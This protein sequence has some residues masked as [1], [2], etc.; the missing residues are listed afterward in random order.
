MVWFR[1]GKS[2]CTQA[3]GFGPLNRF[4]GIMATAAARFRQAITALTAAAGRRSWPDLLILLVASVALTATAPVNGDFWWQ[5]AP[6][7]AL[8][9]AF[10]MDF[11]KAMPWTD[12]TAWAMDYYVKYPA[13]TILFYPPVF[14]FAEAAAYSLFG[15]HHATAQLV[16]GAF[17]LLLATG[18]Y[19]L[20]R[21]ILPRGAAIGVA[22]LLIGAPEAAYWGRQVML[23]IPAYGLL[24][25]SAVFLLCYLGNQGARFIYLAV[26]AFV[27]AIY[28]KYNVAFAVPAMVAALI[29]ARGMGFWRDRNVQFAAAAA[30]ILLMPAAWL[31]S[32]F[33]SINVESVV[34]RSGDLP[35]TD[36]RAWLFYPNLVP[37]Q[38]GVPTTILAIGGLALLLFRGFRGYRVLFSLLGVWLIGGYLLFS[39]VSVREPRHDLMALLPLVLLAGFFLYELLGGNATAQA[40]VII[41]GGLTLAYSIVFLPPPVVTGYRAIADYIAAE[42]PRG[43]TVLFSGYRDGNFVFDM[44]EHS[45]RQDLTLLRADK[46]LLRMSVERTRG[47]QQTDDDEAAISVMLRDQGVAMVVAQAGFWEDLREMARLAHV[48][49]SPD[50]RRVASFQPEGELSTNDGLGSPGGGR[51][52]IYV[53][54]NPVISDRHKVTIEMPFIRGRVSGWSGPHGGG[55][56]GSR[57]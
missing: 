17:V 31:M 51:V 24:V 54:T 40:V 2:Y 41:A 25:W 34:A 23:D 26:G 15:V 5:D 36:L 19:R 21:F 4:G 46:L 6:R 56:A 48:L 16:E 1:H 12:P 3:R 13:L 42:A 49:Q 37:R 50:F 10:V 20:A 45:D 47:V 14:Y 52:D 55:P 28:T 29:A 57:E 18:T 44:R 38:L 22:L 7:H 9:G 39:F 30:I 27:L 53:P 32:H 35:R 33:G 43:G 8:N 11:L